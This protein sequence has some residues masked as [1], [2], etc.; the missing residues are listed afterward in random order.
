MNTEAQ[1]LEP[2]SVALTGALARSWIRNGVAETQ[3]GSH[4]GCLHGRPWLSLI[5]HNTG[6]IKCV[7]LIGC[8]SHIL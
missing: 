1:A 5:V 3:V 6:P 7:D 8:V 2:T 4:I